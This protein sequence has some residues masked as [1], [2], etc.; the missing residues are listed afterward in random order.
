MDR[1][2]ILLV[3][4][5]PFFGGAA[6]LYVGIRFARAF[7][8]RGIDHTE[9]Q[10]LHRRVARLEEELAR[11]AVDV[12]RLEQEQ[13]FTLRLLAERQGALPRTGA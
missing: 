10:A 6:A 13:R 2:L 8:R 4:L 11:A 5:L 12:G 7:E 3:T 9:V 1:F